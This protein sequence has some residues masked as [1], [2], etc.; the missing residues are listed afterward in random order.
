[1]IP[2]SVFPVARGAEEGRK[3]CGV[4]LPR[5]CQR[6]RTQ[7]TIRETWDAVWSLGQKDPLE[8]SMANP[9]QY[10]CLENPMDGGAWRATVHGVAKS[11]TRLKWLSTNY[12]CLSDEFL[13]GTNRNSDSCILPT[14]LRPVEKHCLQRGG[15][16]ICIFKSSSNNYPTS[17]GY[18]WARTWCYSS[19]QETWDSW[20][21]SPRSLNV[22]IFYFYDVFCLFML[23]RTNRLFVSL[24]SHPLK[25][26]SGFIHLVNECFASYICFH[27]TEKETETQRDQGVCFFLSL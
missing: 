1:M 18:H 27:L 8:K 23:L 12:D 22:I 19:P 4:E 13:R 26:L 25:S 6:W 5:W 17:H 14:L 10:S 9:L 20:P 21:T 16:W 15:L 2:H 11:L 7:L 3:G 24:M